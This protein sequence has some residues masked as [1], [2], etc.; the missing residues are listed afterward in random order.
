MRTSNGSRGSQMHNTVSHVA[1]LLAIS[2]AAGCGKKDST[3]KKQVDTATATKPESSPA[4]KAPIATTERAK[5][6]GRWHSVIALVGDEM[7]PQSVSFAMRISAADSEPSVVFSGDTEV[8]ITSVSVE[9]GEVLMEFVQYQTKIVAKFDEAKGSMQGTWSLPWVDGTLD[10]AFTAKRS[11]SG[12]LPALADTSPPLDKAAIAA[13]PTVGGVWEV[14]YPQPDGGEKLCGAYFEQEGSAI[15]GALVAPTGDY[16]HLAGTFQDGKLR[17]YNFDGAFAY[18]V[19]ADAQAD[20]TLLGAGQFNL[21]RQEFTARHIK[22]G[23]LDSELPQCAELTEWSGKGTPLSLTFTDLDGKEFVLADAGLEGKVVLLDFFGTWCPNCHELIPLL[24]AWHKKYQAAGLEIIGVGFEFADGQEAV[25][26]Y[27]DKY[28]IPYR[29]LVGAAPQ[30]AA[31]IM[32]QVPLTSYPTLVLIGRNGKIHNI[33]TG[34]R[35]PATGDFRKADA[36]R[37]EAR[38]TKLLGAGAK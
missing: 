27:R 5:L 12:E 1:I 23:T 16:G 2:L 7:E 13:V 37:F 38:I 10:F 28:K 24:T 35:G 6:A 20:G 4:A 8:P 25:S 3:E 36:A 14:A 31:N 17:L 34:F 9:N 19:S 29:M 26:A 30:D 22:G 32:P 33:Q 15:K 11:D 18:V 21:F